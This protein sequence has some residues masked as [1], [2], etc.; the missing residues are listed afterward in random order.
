M[1]HTA[2]IGI[3]SNLGDPLAQLAQAV[4]RLAGQGIRVRRISSVYRS[5]P[6]GPVREQP[7]FLNAVVEVQTSLAPRPLLE[8]C[9]ALEAEMGRERGLHQGPRIIDLDVLL[10]DDLVVS[11]P[12]LELPHPGMTGRAF[13]LEPLLELAPV[14]TNPRDGEPLQTLRE[15]V[16]HQRIQRLGPLSP[17]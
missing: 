7:D 16:Q 17:A 3:G 4:L 13:V 14:L 12:G 2:Y 9:L 5:E 1:R 8:R 10:V 11:E 6:L 15:K